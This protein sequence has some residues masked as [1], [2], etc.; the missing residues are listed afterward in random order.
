MIRY[1]VT[2]VVMIYRISV[3]YISTLRL[4]VNN[5]VSVTLCVDSCHA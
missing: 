1:K 2:P 4:K 3:R 5:Y